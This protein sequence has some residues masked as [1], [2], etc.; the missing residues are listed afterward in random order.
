MTEAPI[1]LAGTIELPSGSSQGPPGPEGPPGPPG[2]VGPAGPQGPPGSGG[3]GGA[4]VGIPYNYNQQYA[5]TESNTMPIDRSINAN[6]MSQWGVA[7]MIAK[8]PYPP[9]YRI[10]NGQVG[11]GFPAQGATSNGTLPIR[12]Q[13]PVSGNDGRRII[14]VTNATCTVV[15]DTDT[16]GRFLWGLGVSYPSEVGRP[17]NPYLGVFHIINDYRIM[18]PISIPKRSSVVLVTTRTDL[19]DPQFASIPG[20][21]NWSIT[22]NKDNKLY[23][24]ITPTMVN[25]GSARL[26]IRDVMCQGFAISY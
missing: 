16:D 19:L 1:K 9:G 21:P 26:F 24:A 17:I 14:F 2:P 13:P 25:P 5:D 4:W 20:W 12:I 7:M 10:P 22:P 18:Q 23:P 6:T 3:S 11:G 15:N 8:G